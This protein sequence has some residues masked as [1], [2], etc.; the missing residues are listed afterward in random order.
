MVKV[1]S[2]FISQQVAR[3]S[4]NKC[5]DKLLACV[6]KINKGR[7]NTK[8][9]D[10]NPLCTGGQNNHT[11]LCNTFQFFPSVNDKWK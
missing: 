9:T 7:S 11:Q 5:T 10:F 6:D 3:T 4:N 8:K 1:A 2:F